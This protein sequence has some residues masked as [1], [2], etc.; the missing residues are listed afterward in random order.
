MEVSA[1]T[2]GALLPG[3][4]V[5]PG[6]GPAGTVAGCEA[7]FHVAV[8]GQA[9]EAIVGDAWLYAVGP[10]TSIAVKSVVT[11]GYDKRL[12]NVVSNCP[13]GNEDARVAGFVCTRDAY[14]SWLLFRA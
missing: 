11:N 12:T 8:F 2:S 6:G 4:S 10:G 5:L 14:A 7:V 3:A 1:G 9:V 13:E